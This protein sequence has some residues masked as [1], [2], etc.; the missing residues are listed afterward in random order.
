[1]R[2]SWAILS[3]LI[4]TTA[5][6]ATTYHRYTNARFGFS[7]LVPDFLTADPPP[8]NGDGLSWRSK[9]D[10]IQMTAWGM[11]NALDATLGTAYQEWL[12]E[13][14]TE[15]LE[16]DYKVLRDTFWVISYRQGRE[17]IYLRQT[18]S[19]EAKTKNQKPRCFATLR[20]AY[21]EYHRA[22]MDAVTAKVSPSLTRPTGD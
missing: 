9:D 3:L 7:V 12:D 21:D 20:L 10:R 15:G 17:I 8:E 1:M 6:A 18:S 13:L 4:L 11:N 2:K 14:A 22:R 5:L 19:R 16:P